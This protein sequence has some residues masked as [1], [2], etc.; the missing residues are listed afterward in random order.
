MLCGCTRLSE[1]LAG[2]CTL[3]FEAAESGCPPAGWLLSSQMFCMRH[4]CPLPALRLSVPSSACLL[5]MSLPPCIRSLYTSV[6]LL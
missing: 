1:R 4:G 2:T 5:Y 6:N 3:V